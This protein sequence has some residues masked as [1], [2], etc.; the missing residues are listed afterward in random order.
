MLAGVG[1][2]QGASAALAAAYHQ[3]LPA[4][5]RLAAAVPHGSRWDSATFHSSPEAREGDSREAAMSSTFG[6][7]LTQRKEA[8]APRGMDP[9]RCCIVGSGPAGFYAAAKLLRR[10]GSHA[11]VDIIERLPTP[12]G[13]VRS[14]VAPDHADTKNV[15]GQFSRVG[16][17]PRCRFLGN[18]QLGRHVSVEELQSMYNVV[19]L[20]YGSQGDRSLD[21]P[22]ENLPGVLSAKQFVGWYNGHPDHSTLPIDLSRTRSVAVLGL[23][24]VALDVAR[25]L[26]APWKELA[27]TDITSDAVRQLQT[28]V[29][30]AVHIVGRRG[31]VQAAY[32]PKEL[33]EVLSMPSLRLRLHDPERSLNLSPSDAEDAA[34]HRRMRRN[35]EVLKKAY[36]DRG[37]LP[38]KDGQRELHLH[39]WKRPMELRGNAKDG[40]QSL[41]LEDTVVEQ[42][43]DGR[44]T[45]RGTGQVSEVPVDLV[46]KAVGYKSLALPGVPFDSDR[47][48][49]PNEAGRVLD[50]NGEPMPGLYVTGWLRRGPTG[51]IATNL[52]DAEAEVASGEED[53]ESLLLKYMADQRLW[54]HVSSKSGAPRHSPDDELQR[55]AEEAVDTITDDLTNGRVPLL[56]PGAPEGEAGLQPLL[57]KRGVRVVSWDDWEAIDAEERSRGEEKGKVREKFTSVEEMIAFLDDR[58]ASA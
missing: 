5:T 8:T 27:A 6:G 15:T 11:T 52:H 42:L 58:A 48:V 57:A 4:L 38:T 3:W 56:P 55:D 40:V 45:L 36:E 46:L 14:G 53:N 41:V 17:D 49:V 2:G 19:V 54:G 35:Y 22:G 34:E 20:A 10:W 39:F 44:R 43:A 26:G 13:L 25:V 50:D 47:G 12:Y 7:R 24:N 28:S 29:V 23:G 37:R 30:Q 32:T 51:I 31:P 9:V 16:S 18:V 1:P 33:R 21:I